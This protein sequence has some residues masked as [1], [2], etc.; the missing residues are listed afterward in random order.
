MHITNTTILSSLYEK[1][2]HVYTETRD[3]AAYWT[4][5]LPYKQESYKGS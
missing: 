5:H 4:G 3:Q 1:Q 2:H